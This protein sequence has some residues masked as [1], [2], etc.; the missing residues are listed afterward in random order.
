M[1]MSDNNLLLVLVIIPIFSAIFVSR[2]PH[3]DMTSVRQITTTVLT[4]WLAFLLKC[5][6]IL[7][8]SEQ[9]LTWQLNYSLWLDDNVLDLSLGQIQFVLLLALWFA[10]FSLF[11]LNKRI[12]ENKGL[13]F[14]VIILL[15]LALATLTILSSTLAVSIITANL[16]VCLFLFLCARHGGSEKGN[17][18]LVSSLFFLTVDIFSI[19]VLFLPKSVWLVAGYYLYWIALA[20]ALTRLLIPFFAPFSR[21]MFENSSITIIILYVAFIIPTGAALLFSIKNTLHL[22]QP[23]FICSPVVT[24]LVFAS[25]FFS[26]LWII[27]EKDC[28]QIG[29]SLLVFYNAIFIN[30]VLDPHHDA[31]SRAAILMLFCAV[32]CASF[33]LYVGQLLFWELEHELIDTT[34]NHLW[35]ASLALWFPLPGLGIGTALWLGY[36]DLFSSTL[37]SPALNISFWL[38]IFLLL[39]TALIQNYFRHI[40]PQTTGR[41]LL[42]YRPRKLASLQNA[43]ASFAVVLLLCLVSSTYFLNTGA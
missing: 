23:A 31:S 43:W 41:S 25:S 5:G 30:F 21:T 32:I 13:S 33:T 1:T 10:L 18:V 29:L 4:V 27:T 39:I 34:I 2:I 38:I 26:A 15:L 9:R 24:I 12:T 19:A 3:F 8:S 22:Y 6:H 37:L 16:S 35:L 28:R 17:A 36:M 7:F 11:F 20:P 42:G 14:S 40:D